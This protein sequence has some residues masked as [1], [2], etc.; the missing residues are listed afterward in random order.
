MTYSNGRIDLG[1]ALS[2]LSSLLSL[3]F[4]KRYHIWLGVCFSVLALIHT[5]QHRKQA[6]YYLQKE[7]QHMNF[8]SQLKTLTLPAK[9]AYL[10]QHVE[11]LHYIP[12]RVRLF[13]QQLVNNTAAASDLTSYLSAI[14]EIKQFSVNAATGSVLIQYW[15]AD[16]ANT[17]L[18]QELEQLV[19]KR[20]GR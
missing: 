7:R 2:L 15:P 20:Y 5:W 18:L 6:S 12:G 1:L 8:L 3:P 11:V 4:N 13:S 17:P 16:V 19:A 10:M 9:K 14:P